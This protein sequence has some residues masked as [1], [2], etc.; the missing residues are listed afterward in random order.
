MKRGK[1][2]GFYIAAVLAA[3]MPLLTGGCATSGGF[4]WDSEAGRKRRSAD[5]SAAKILPVL[6]QSLRSTDPETRNNA[7]QAIDALGRAGRSAA[8]DIIRLL[9][10]PVKRVSESAAA[11]LVKMGP[12]A[13][14]PLIDAL[15][16]SGRPGVRR[17]A[18]PVLAR[19]GAAAAPALPTL[20]A[21]AQ[22][23]DPVIRPRAAAAVNIIHSAAGT[24]KKKKKRK[25]KR[26]RRVK[27][28]AA[29]EPA[30]APRA[31]SPPP[32]PMVSGPMSIAELVGGLKSPD[33]EYRRQAV[34]AL[35]FK[36]AE[37]GEVLPVLI[38]VALNDADLGV[39]QAAAGKLRKMGKQPAS[40]LILALTHP[41]ASV[42]RNAV[43]A[44]GTIGPVTEAVLPALIGAFED[45][46]TRDAAVD[47]LGDIGQKSVPQ[48]IEALHD[49][50]IY[51]AAGK[52]LV[53]IGRS[54]TKSLAKGLDNGSIRSRVSDVLV[55]IGAPSVPA[56]ITS[57]MTG[58]FEARAG[59]LVRIG[60]VAVP[61][62]VRALRTREGK[63]RQSSG[64]TLCEM[65]PSA[66]DALPAFFEVLK[67]H[68][69][70]NEL[71]PLWRFG[72]AGAPAL[73][74]AA[75]DEDPDIRLVAVESLGRLNPVPEEAIRV[76]ID[77]LHDKDARIGDYSVVAI[78]DLGAKAIPGLTDALQSLARAT[79]RSAAE[80]LG[81]IGNPA[82]R[83]IAPLR[84]ALL[85]SD[86]AGLRKRAA[87]ALGAL[88]SSAK[89]AV[90]DLIASLEDAEVRW[91][92]SEAL[93][94]IGSATAPAL[95]KM[96]RGD[97][98]ARRFRAALLLNQLEPGNERVPAVLLAGLQA[99]DSGVR[100]QSALALGA[101][102]GLA[103]QSVP[104]LTQSLKDA[105]AGVR[106]G[107]AASLARLGPSSVEPL[108]LAAIETESPLSKGALNALRMLD[109]GAAP[110]LV[111]SLKNKNTRALATNVLYRMGA[112]AVPALIDGLNSQG[113]KSRAGRILVRI[114]TP[115]VP[116][117]TQAVNEG[118][119]SLK[120]GAKL[121]LAEIMGSGGKP[122]L[123]GGPTSKRRSR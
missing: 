84:E 75:A 51:A 49:D 10:D 36:P 68:P 50:K 20:Q 96:L 47:A 24:V 27:R 117:L 26:K 34:E 66:A 106:F 79:S 33:P 62:L 77:A 80:A 21:L 61:D 87:Y 43:A 41:E 98:D 78:K 74:E 89:S 45:G 56:L 91:W 19:L 67:K 104:I 71:Y 101:N 42:R 123:K 90:G 29:V 48:L 81:F 115:A 103:A 69:D 86:D 22:G 60:R 31:P 52:T 122:K 35:T 15:N 16:D 116:A 23:D 83:A 92:A 65:G 102:P 40:A 119:D 112:K 2:G 6:L 25:R 46:K 72:Q 55:E 59:V 108:L 13:V 9:D 114:G 99:A 118:R 57:F 54:A 100:Y 8:P 53:R 7:V 3:L 32:K 97:A 94:K 93:R 11:A 5:A 38:H 110:A 109:A 28:T 73:I 120:K 39:R 121:T 44:L 37:A 58:S 14:D 70:E 82:K 30:P 18:L 64:L 85:R 113:P 63:V 105:D 88:G 76:F 4:G 111:R 17:E 12:D 1:T 95:E 107:A